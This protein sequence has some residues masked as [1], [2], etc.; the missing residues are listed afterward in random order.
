MKCVVIYFSQTGNTEK[1]AKAVQTGVKQ[2]AGHCD[3]VKIKEADPRRL[4][5]YDLIG[6]G[7]PVFHFK[8][9]GNIDAFINN[10]RFVGGK[11]IFS[12]CTHCTM[13]MLYFPSIV[14]KLQKKGLVVIG[15]RDWYGHS[16]GPIIQPTPYL[17]DGHPDEIDLREAE[18][19]G[20]EMVRRSQRIYAGETNLIPRTPA[21]VP[22][23]VVGEGGELFHI[24]FKDFVR[25]DRGKCRY[26]QCRLCM[27]NCPM[28]GID[29]TVE[30]P[31][32]AKPCLDCMFC[33]AIC[34]SGA[35]S[36]DDEWMVAT[37]Q[38][39]SKVLKSTGTKELAKAEAQGH[40][41]RLFPE[42]KVGWD[43]PVYKVHSKRPRWI[44]GKGPQ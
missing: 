25:Y 6:L 13:R 19:F 33:E 22:P 3:I 8:E 1:V 24:S 28:D 31:I 38:D 34:P 41:R 39:V 7:S 37:A 16:W 2:A 5:E 9:P 23:P 18:D 12:F 14:P 40:F 35:L 15:W 27:D 30:P 17:T 21:K 26:P 42:E 36:A 20:R 29:L 11:H 43:T 32:I 44:I 4:Y 10:M